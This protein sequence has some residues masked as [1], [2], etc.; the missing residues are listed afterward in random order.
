MLGG[1]KIKFRRHIGR[2]R[3]THPNHNKNTGEIILKRKN[4]RTQEFQNPYTKEKCSVYPAIAGKNLKLLEQY[5]FK[6]HRQDGLQ[7]KE[8]RQVSILGICPVCK[9]PMS[10]CDGN[11]AVCRNPDCKG[12]R[13]T[14]FENGEEVVRYNHTV[15]KTIN[16]DS[17]RYREKLF[18]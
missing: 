15:Y 1:K 2:D 3:E 18:E 9:Q 17:Q 4:E 16:I 11:I 12:T 10:Y 8:K 7:N 13:Y 6:I 14:V 5:G